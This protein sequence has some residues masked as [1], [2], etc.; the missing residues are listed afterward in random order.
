MEA[1]NI[2]LNELI[3][4]PTCGI[5]YPFKTSGQCPFCEKS[6]ETAFAL[7]IQRWDL[8]TFYDK[9]TNRVEEKYGLQERVYEEIILDAVT[10]KYVKAFHLLI[11]T[12]E[13]YDSPICQIK[14]EVDPQT[15][16]VLLTVKPQDDFCFF[17]KYANGK[18][19]ASF[20]EDQVIRLK[21]G[22]T[23]KIIIGSNTFDHAQRVIVI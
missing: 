2:A 6:S 18:S 10:P 9:E 5:H 17:Y 11:G 15:E 16:D 20:D 23:R 21:K 4:C 3:K 22:R 13:S 8:D 12:E 7:K 19:E 14:L 1:L